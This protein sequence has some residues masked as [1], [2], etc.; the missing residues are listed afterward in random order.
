MTTP[1][2]SNLYAFVRDLK[3]RNSS[4]ET[5]RSYTESV[6][7]LAA[8]V[9]KHGLPSEPISI[10]R[11]T[12]ESYIASILASRM[13]TT[14]ATR[15]RACKAFFR[16]L[17][18]EGELTS[19]M[20][21][22][23]APTVPENPPPLLD[24]IQL[25]KLIKS[26]DD[27][28]EGRRDEAILRVLIDGGPRRSELTNMRLEDLDLNHG[29]IWVTGKGNRRRRVPLTAVTVRALDRYLR[30]RA[31]HPQSSSSALWLGQ[32][33]QLSDS[34][35][36]Q[37]VSSRGRKAGLRTRPHLLRHVSAH[38]YLSNGGREGDLMQLMGWRSRAMLNRYGASAASDRALAAFKELDLSL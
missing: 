3:A 38:R 8:Y 25:K 33:G 22:M 21:G 27:T 37:V 6:E 24:D 36:A 31:V 11:E 15:F 35:I 30:R 12:V 18:D 17:E 2:R 28:F 19:P 32:R 23:K 34:G 13:P 14:A 7:Q 4:R 1:L 16:Y 10:S 5:I 20:R 9:E 26:C 29:F